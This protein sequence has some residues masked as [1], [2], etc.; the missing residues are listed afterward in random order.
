MAKDYMKVEKYHWD[1][2]PCLEQMAI[3]GC[4]PL[5]GLGQIIAESENAE[6]YIKDVGYLIALMA[7]DMHDVLYRFLAEINE[8]KKKG[9]IDV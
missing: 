6:N 1:G 4:N 9:K 3:W 5:A 8:Q 2:G 7:E